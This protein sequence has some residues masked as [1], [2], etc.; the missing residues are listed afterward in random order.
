MIDHE[1]VV[2]LT[3]I[4]RIVSEAP[5]QGVVAPITDER[6]VTCS[7][8]QR[9]VQI[10]ADERVA[11]AAARD[12]DRPGR[13]RG[14]EG[15]GI[16]GGRGADSFDLAS[17]EVEGHATGGTV[18]GDSVEART[19]YDAGVETIDHQMVVSFAAIERIVSEAPG[20]GV[21]A[22]VA[23]ERVIAR[24]TVQRVVQ[25]AADE[26]VAAAAARDV[27]RPGRSRGIEGVGI[28]GGRG[29]DSFDLA[30]CE[31]EGHATVGSAD[32]DPVEARATHDA[33]V[34]VVDRKQVVPLTT[35]I[36]IS[37]ESPGQDIVTAVADQ[38]VVA[39]STDQ[40]VTQ[41]AADECVVAAAAR[42]VDHPGGP[43]GIEGVS[44]GRSRCI[45]GFDLT[46]GQVQRHAAQ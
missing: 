38:G 41:R 9:V 5:G 42:D 26:R 11:A 30:S 24:S 45:G 3:T 12:V 36:C 39:R 15:V 23:H 8:V 33:G 27:D 7:T 22:P 40:S 10:A 14:I 25:I 2:P 44:V 34:E 20:Q 6:V 32:D 31:V 16:A 18:D 19:T 37:P 17:C 4:E 35:V 29:A 1:Q 28:A 43:R 13:S 46:T 21:M